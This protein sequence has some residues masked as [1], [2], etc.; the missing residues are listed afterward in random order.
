MRLTWSHRA[1][2]LARAGLALTLGAGLAATALPAHASAGPA[3]HTTAA[4]TTS[5]T[6]ASGTS[7]SN[8]R[9][10]GHTSATATPD[11][12]WKAMAAA[13]AA[14]KNTHHATSVE[15][16]TNAYATLVANADG[17][18]TA[19]QYVE[20][21]RAKVDGKWRPIDTTLVK[22]ADGTV[23]AAATAAA[24]T[25]SGGG[26]GALATVDD[27]SGHV[28]TFSWPGG[29]LPAPVLHGD[30]ATYPNVYPGVDLQMVVQP[31]GVQN[32]FVVHD[33]KAAAN[34]A[35]KSLGL[36]VSGKGLTISATAGG[37]VAAKDA[38]GDVLF[39]GP[40]PQMWDAAA[41]AATATGATTAHASASAPHTAVL[42][43]GVSKGIVSVAPDRAMLSDPKASFPLV[44]DP[45]WTENP[46]NWVELWSNGKTVY[47]GNPAPYTGYDNR[48]VRVGNSAGTLV[49]SLFSFS[50]MPLP[51]P[52]NYDA[53]G[54][55]Q[56]A[57]YV[58]S[59]SVN[60]TAQSAY[61]PS[62][63]VWR[64]NPFG[65]ASAWSNQNSP[66]LWPPS[67][68]DFSN[69]MTTLGGFSNCAGHVW[70]I[71]DTSQV[72]DV[73]NSGGGS[74]TIGLRAANE[75]PTTNNYG[76]FWVY[77]NAA[78]VNMSVNFA[79]EP[80][81]LATRIGTAPVGNHGGQ[82]TVCSTDENSPGYLP[83]TT[84][85]IPVQADI[86][87]WDARP[88]YYQFFIN[89][90]TNAGSLPAG[91]ERSPRPPTPT[92]VPSRARPDPATPPSPARSRRAASTAC[93]T[94]AATSCSRRCGTTAATPSAP[95]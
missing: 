34:P 80:F 16:A 65:T 29:A 52:G 32:L 5:A 50:A 44:I 77:N 48:A 24:V 41:T 87:D 17:T 27:G 94:A 72:Q 73:Y 35:L 59:A 79:A 15:S 19:R 51:R 14:A 11:P 57:V 76:S 67:G 30:T 53:V 4:H 40:A 13:S 70:N 20:P 46:Q 85:T 92:R 42:K 3:R 64:A 33:A 36:K 18:F 39:G 95:G 54:A 37:G 6:A 66:Q 60:L 58:I 74:Y 43:A 71:N 8:A 82:T 89:G 61:C 86:A 88:V 90:S 22:A 84:G 12:L 23:H 38:K 28:L 25:L 21:Q 93:R 75:S 78:A 49:R 2:P 68:S 69:P 83:L 63:Q 56:Q 47:D 31:A 91:S 7:G 26:S 62:T 1:R 10:T 81:G 9:S 55:F 45:V